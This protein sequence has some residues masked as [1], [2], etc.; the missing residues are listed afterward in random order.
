MAFSDAVARESSENLD[1]CMQS[2][3]RRWPRINS[4]AAVV[5]ETS[6]LATHAFG[7]LFGLWLLREPSVARRSS[8]GRGEGDG[9]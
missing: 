4:I 6:G 5:G 3:Q 7:S 2:G 1:R 8:A 9:R